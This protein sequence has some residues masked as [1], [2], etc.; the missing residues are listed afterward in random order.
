MNGFA[1]KVG[2]SCVASK[3]RRLANY[4]L[5]IIF[6]R[7]LLFPTWFLIGYFAASVGLIDSDSAEWLTDPIVDWSLSIVSFFF[8][9]FAFETMWQRTPAKF[10]TGTK[11]L[12]YD[13]TKPTARTIAVRTLARLVPFEPFSFLGK[14]AYGWHDKW[15]DTTIVRAKRIEQNSTEISLTTKQGD[16]S[17]GITALLEK[18]YSKEQTAEETVAQTKAVPDN[19]EDEKQGVVAEQIGPVR[20]AQEEDRM[21]DAVILSQTTK[22]AKEQLKWLV[23]AIL[24]IILVI[25]IKPFI[26]VPYSTW[27]DKRDLSTPSDRLIG[28]WSGS[29][30]LYYSAVDPQLKIGCGIISNSN[31]DIP[32]KFKILW[33]ESSGKNI[34]TRE[35][36]SDGNFYNV[37]C[38][39]SNDGQSMTKEYTD[40]DGIRSLFVYHYIDSWTPK[41]L[42]FRREL[43][44]ISIDEFRKKY[45][46]YNN[47]TDLQIT[48]AIHKKYFTDVSFNEFARN[49]G[50]K[51]E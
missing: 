35:F 39:I 23:V 50:V 3:T 24:A 25:L 33:E 20:I 10:I 38:C 12:N 16:K 30:K 18:E 27:A 32:F 2:D 4:F 45:P 9:Y 6:F 15:P 46:Q 44:E 1:D 31:N 13:G 40:K 43:E 26:S 19:F 41:E 47:M 42:K 48:R 8:Y 14:E 21:S 51:T 36:F 34:K 37:D 11:V 22:S 28:H 5:D 29:T 49:F 7:I 17:I